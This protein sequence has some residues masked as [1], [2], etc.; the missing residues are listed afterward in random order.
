MSICLVGELIGRPV[1]ERVNQ[2]HNDEMA[3]KG[4]YV[5]ELDGEG[6]LICAW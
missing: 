6:E 2:S 1:A 3:K 4:T 5:I